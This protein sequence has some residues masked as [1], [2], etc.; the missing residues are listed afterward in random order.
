MKDR[1]K[2]LKQLIY[3]RTELI[4]TAKKEIKQY[5]QEIEQINGYKKLEKI[6]SIRRSHDKR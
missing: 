3:L 4:K 6:N 5:H 2:E 1:E